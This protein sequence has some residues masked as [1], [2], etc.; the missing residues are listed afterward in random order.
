MPHSSLA[1]VRRPLAKDFVVPVP[2]FAVV[3]GVL[4]VVARPFRHE[5]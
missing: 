4:T 5:V 2:G 3:P 1:V